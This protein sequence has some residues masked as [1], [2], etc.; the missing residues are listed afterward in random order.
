MRNIHVVAVLL[1]LHVLTVVSSGLV[2]ETLVLSVNLNPGAGGHGEGAHE[3][4]LVI[5]HLDAEPQATGLGLVAH[6][7]NL[8]AEAH[9]H[10]DGVAGVAGGAAGVDHVHTVEVALH[11]E[12][13]LIAAAGKHDALGSA[14]ALL[15]ALVVHNAA[16]DLALSVD[17]ELGQRALPL[18]RDVLAGLNG[19]REAAPHAT[20]LEGSASRSVTDVAGAAHE[21]GAVEVRE[22]GDELA[23]GDGAAG[24]V[25]ELIAHGR[26]GA[27]NPLGLI[28]ELLAHP[29]EVIL[30]DGVGLEARS[31][32]GLE[33]VDIIGRRNDDG[34]AGSDGVTASLALV[35]LLNDKNVGIGIDVIGLE[36]SSL[37]S[38]T[39]THDEEVYLAVELSV[40]ALGQSQ[41]SDGG[42]ARRGG[43][44]SGALEQ[45]P[46]R[47]CLGHTF[48]PFSWQASCL[49]GSSRPFAR[50]S[51][52]H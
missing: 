42:E 14:D 18:D 52:D 26:N 22:L 20:V 11:L 38:K 41:R 46:T 16:D 37:A 35:E 50:S 28:S 19:T 44:S 15:G 9:E 24:D 32:V 43:A 23:P 34:L 31:D 40:L 1:V 45:I 13:V 5:R 3:G 49:P 36:G 10:L 27:L 21:A 6:V 33:G 25:A 4:A 7:P 51:I 47:A 2:V 12:V 29:V 48:P 39:I 30:G 8:S 17:D